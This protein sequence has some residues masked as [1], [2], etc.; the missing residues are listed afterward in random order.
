[1][2][3]IIAIYKVVQT[4]HPGEMFEPTIFSSVGGDD[5]HYATPPWI[6]IYFLDSGEEQSF[7]EFSSILI[8]KAEAHWK[9]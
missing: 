5:D 6:T 2:N 1:M 3:N 7:L 9:K 4:T 8:P